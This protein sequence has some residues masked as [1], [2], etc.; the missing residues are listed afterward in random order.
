MNGWQRNIALMI[1][2]TLT[3][4]GSLVS[5]PVANAASESLAQSRQKIEAVSN[6][7]M[8]PEHER[9]VLKDASLRGKQPYIALDALVKQTDGFISYNKENDTVDIVIN[10]IPF[11]LLLREQSIMSN[12]YEISGDFYITDNGDVYLSVE[13]AAKLSKLEF[14][15]E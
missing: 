1:M 2:A 6:E 10:D 7:N 15:L 13:Q 5:K 9:I 8:T 11:S 12:G 3:L 4:L 14:A